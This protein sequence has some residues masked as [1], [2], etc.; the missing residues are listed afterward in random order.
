MNPCDEPLTIPATSTVADLRTAL[1]VGAGP[2]F[3]F[4]GRML[5][6]DSKN[7]VEYGAESGITII[8]Q[9]RPEQLPAA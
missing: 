7:L 4:L 6:D 3:V 2:R 1:G 5:D 8:A 9:G